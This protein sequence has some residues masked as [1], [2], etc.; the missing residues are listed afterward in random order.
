MKA[1]QSKGTR[2]R[3]DKSESKRHIGAVNTKTET[4]NCW[5]PGSAAAAVSTLPTPVGKAK[6]SKS[7]GLNV[8]A[9]SHVQLPAVGSAAVL[10]LLPLPVLALLLLLLALLLLALLPLPPLQIKTTERINRS[11]NLH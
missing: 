5:S 1:Q 9:E 4:F 11:H 3:I 6:K 8:M 7:V 2:T 10:G